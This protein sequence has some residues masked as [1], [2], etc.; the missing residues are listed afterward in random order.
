MRLERGLRLPA[1]RRPLPGRPQARPA[2]GRDRR[3][4]TWSC[5]P[6]TE[7]RLYAGFRERG[8]AARVRGARDRRAAAS[9]ICA[10]TPSPA[11]W[12]SEAPA[13]G[14]AGLLGEGLARGGDAAR[15]RSRPAELSRR[16][17]PQ[18]S[19]SRSP[20]GPARWF[21]GRYPL[22][23]ALAAAF[24]IVE[25]AAA[26]ASAWSISV[27]AVDAPRTQE[28]YVNPA[29]GL[30]EDECRFVMAHELLHVGLRHDGRRQ[31]RDPY[32]W[33]VACDYVIN[34]WL[35]E[36][37]VG[38]MPAFGVLYDPELKGESA[39]AI[40]D[41]IAT[42]LRRYRKLAR[43][44]GVGLGRHAA[45]RARLVGSAATAATS[46]TSTAA[47]WRRGWTTTSAAGA[48]CCRRGWS[49]RSA[50]W[51]S[52]R[53]P[54]TSSW[55]AGSTRTSRRWSKRPHLRPAQPPPVVHAGHPPA[56]LGGRPRRRRGAHLRRRAG[57]LRLDGPHAAG[58]GARRHR[59]LRP[60][61]RR[62]GACGWSSA[63][64]SPTTQGYLPPEAIAGRVRVRGRGGTVLQP[65]IDLL[66][67]RRDF[68]DDGPLLVITDGWCDGSGSGASTP[69]CCR[70][71]VAAVR[72]AG[73]GVSGSVTDLTTAEDTISVEP[74]SP[75][76]RGP[77]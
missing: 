34:G 41:R 63:T 38:E 50:R 4:R 73:A 45:G 62:A 27:A 69:S 31:G 33:N 32:L 58:Q 15:S 52:R 28:I 54:G 1:C 20:S 53:S 5:R 71:A 60:R 47:P 23:G 22:L 44:A 74:A 51:S 36:M 64:P 17:A 29:A 6:T 40:Y 39:E 9:R 77:V 10:S 56:A 16:S 46:T 11:S 42:D 66:E 68:P 65:G 48:G 2:A 70:R 12:A 75:E 8:R 7:E 18:R 3:C 61:A 49:R 55:R 26:S 25:D 57:H 13:G 72:A 76:D 59:Q 21:V 24:T 35:V 43:C 19:A 30:D 37:G 14:L 67:R